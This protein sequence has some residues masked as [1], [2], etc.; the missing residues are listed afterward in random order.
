MIFPQFSF[1]LIDGGQKRTRTSI[2]QKAGMQRTLLMYIV[3]FF[4]IKIHS[5]TLIAA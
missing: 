1:N 4:F 5:H 3:I 2:A